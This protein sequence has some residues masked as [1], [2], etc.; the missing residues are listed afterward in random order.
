MIKLSNFIK[1]ASFSLFIIYFNVC[2][3]TA[4]IYIS[5]SN[6]EKISNQLKSNIEIGYIDYDDILDSLYYNFES[7][8]II[9]LLSESNYVPYS[10]NYVPECI[11]YLTVHK[12]IIHIYEL[13]MRSSTIL[14]YKYEKDSKSFRLISLF[15]EDLGP[16]SNDG[17]GSC[18]LDL[19]TGEFEGNW[20]YYDIEH[21]SL[22]SMPPITA[23]I[24]N[25]PSYVNE[26]TRVN[27]PCDSIFSCY[28]NKLIINERI[29]KIPSSFFN[30]TNS[31]STIHNEVLIDSLYKQSGTQ[32]CYNEKKEYDV[33][34]K[35]DCEKDFEC[36]VKS[37][38]LFYDKN[39]SYNLLS[40]NFGF[41]RIVYVI[42]HFNKRNLKKQF[43]ELPFQQIEDDYIFVKSNTNNNKTILSQYKYDQ[44][45]TQLEIN[46]TTNINLIEQ[47]K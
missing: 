25:P 15:Q 28:K 44:L 46:T 7:N 37:I 1:K 21:D 33:C 17:S 40:F 31:I 22:I 19:E 35:R 3:V 10:I 30:N 41:N 6:G 16:A 23:H 5:G 32:L 42:S 39:N 2:N 13:Y 9:I 14:S 45:I 12:N 8:T 43:I 29:D 38:L 26:Y 27:F 11:S 36:I 47:K 20:N 18:S 34:S 4:Q 24:K